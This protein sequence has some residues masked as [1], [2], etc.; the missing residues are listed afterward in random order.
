MFSTFKEFYQANSVEN[1]CNYLLKTSY[2][3]PRSEMPQIAGK[4]YQ[5]F[6]DYLQSKS[7]PVTRE[8]V[9]LKCI[10]LT[11]NELNVEKIKTL[12]GQTF[13]TK[14]ILLSSDYHV[15]DGS[16]RFVSDYIDANGLGKIE[17]YKIGLEIEELIQFTHSYPKSFRKEIHENVV[18]V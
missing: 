15:L 6:L 16:H 7:V 2:H 3:I 12:L 4:D 17:V 8:L 1:T 10:R 5:D 13:D 9:D 14:P 11:Q 18:R